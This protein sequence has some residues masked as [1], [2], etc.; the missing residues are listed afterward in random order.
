ML[1]IENET[2]IISLKI[3]NGIEKKPEYNI[4]IIEYNANIIIGMSGDIN[5][6]KIFSFQRRDFA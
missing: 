5:F 6:S 2:S 4:D 3:W 1:V